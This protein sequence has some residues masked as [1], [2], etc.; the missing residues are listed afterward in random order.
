[1]STLFVNTPPPPT[2]PLRFT[3]DQCCTTLFSHPSTSF[4]LVDDCAGGTYFV[5]HGSQRV[6]VFKPSVSE[7]S[8][9]LN[10]KGDCETQLKAGFT[11]GEGYLR[12]ICAYQMDHAGFAGVPRTVFAEVSGERLGLGSNEV[13]GSFQ[14]FVTHGSS[15]WDSPPGAYSGKDVRRIALLDLRLLNCDRHGGNILVGSDARTLTPID[16]G[17]VLPTSLEDLDFEWLMWP[18]AKQPFTE[19]E[20]E[21]ILALCADDDAAVL[22][23]CGVGEDAVELMRLALC[24][25]QV[26]VC[27]DLTV[28]DIGDFFRRSH[29][30]APSRLEECI[31]AARLSDDAGSESSSLSELVELGSDTSSGEVDFWYVMAG[32]GF[33]LF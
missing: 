28:R 16:H 7:P 25:L 18:Q 5:S 20:K 24:A 31:E 32:L 23:G 13:A 12:E 26:G 30:G 14:H 29:F 17:Y 4:T 11:P 6:G 10:P 3:P 15:S 33:M 9:P 2:P 27:A 22:R 8:Q 21:Y 19:E 1:M